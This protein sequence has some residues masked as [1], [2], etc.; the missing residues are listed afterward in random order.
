MHSDATQKTIGLT[1]CI[2]NCATTAENATGKNYIQ[3]SQVK[4]YEMIKLTEVLHF[5]SSLSCFC[6][7]CRWRASFSSDILILLARI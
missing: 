7:S 4:K 3:K 5:S 1:F 6:W 2:A